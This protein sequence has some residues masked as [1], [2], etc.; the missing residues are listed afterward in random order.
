MGWT[1]RGV[2]LAT[3]DTNIIVVPFS[4]SIIADGAAVEIGFIDRIDYATRR[5]VDR[6]RHLCQSDAGRVVEQ[7]PLPEDMTLTATGL[8]L[9]NSSIIGRLTG[10]A[11]GRKIESAY[12][13]FHTLHS[14]AYPFEIEVQAV[15][16]GDD[17]QKFTIIYGECWL[18]DFGMPINIGDSS[19]AETA[20]IQPSWGETL[21][22]SV[23]KEPGTGGSGIP[24]FGV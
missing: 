2:V 17:N 18:T 20:T 6:K 21:V 19:I 22:D 15:H 23:I 14:Q 24:A 9:Y 16:P 7:V 5:T 12:A 13:L 4:I 1:S 10:Q 11:P 3:P 8:G